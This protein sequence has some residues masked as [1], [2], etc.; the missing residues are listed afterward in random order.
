[1]DDFE[2]YYISAVHFLS[3]RNRSEKEVR[4]NLKTKKTPSD[5]LEKVVETL[6]KQNF[7]NDKKFVE[8]WIDQRNTFKPRS[9]RLL[10]MELKQKGVSQDIIE[11]G[12]MNQEPGIESD[13]ALAKKLVEKKIGRYKGFAKRELYE[14]LGPFLA[15]KGFGW[16]TIK[17]SIDEVLEEGV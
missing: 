8:W 2:K 6:K 14:K 13:L 16:E 10:E 9:N 1:M 5:I 7:I 3:F 17:K 12:I 11:S 15:R 4:D